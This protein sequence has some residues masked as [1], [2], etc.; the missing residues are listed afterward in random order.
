MNID[1]GKCWAALPLRVCKQ[2]KNGC[3]KALEWWLVVH[4]A[5]L[6]CVALDVVGRAEALSSLCLPSLSAG[7]RGMTGDVA[8]GLY[9]V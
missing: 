2:T 8:A 4:D 6:A 3:G 5:A 9:R 7:Y 1:V